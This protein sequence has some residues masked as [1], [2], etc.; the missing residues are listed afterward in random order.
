M[1]RKLAILLLAWLLPTGRTSEVPVIGN[2]DQSSNNNLNLLHGGPTTQYATDNKKFKIELLLPNLMVESDNQDSLVTFN[3]N[4]KNTRFSYNL[5]GIC[6]DCEGIG[7]SA[8]GGEEDFVTYESEVSGVSAIICVNGPHLSGIITDVGKGTNFEIRTNK[9]VPNTY[10]Y[11]GS[12]LEDADIHMTYDVSEEIEVEPSES[13]SIELPGHRKML[14]EEKEIMISK[15]V[16][17]NISPR[18]STSGTEN[19]RVL[20]DDDDGSEVTLLYYITKRQ[21][22]SWT[23]QSY[24]S[25]ILDE[26]KQNELETDVAVITAYANKALS[27]SDVYFTFVTVKVHVDETNDE[28]VHDINYDPRIRLHEFLRLGRYG[29]PNP[30]IESL[31]DEYHADLVVD[32][33]Y[34]EIAPNS[35][36]A[37]GVGWVPEV[38]PARNQGYSSTGGSFSM[39]A[40]V[41]THEIGHNMGLN[42]N[43][44]QEAGG[45]KE[46]YYGW[47]DCE[48]C[49]I[50]IM[51]YTNECYETCDGNVQKI[52]YFSNQNKKFNG[53][54][55]GDQDND[56]ASVLNLTKEGVAMQRYTAPLKLIAVEDPYVSQISWADAALVFDVVPKSDIILNNI[57]FVLSGAGSFSVYI[58]IGSSIGNE[59]NAEFW[60]SPHMKGTV[61]PR[62]PSNRFLN[63]GQFED[64]T[65]LMLLANQVYAIKISRNPGSNDIIGKFSASRN[66]AQGDVIVENDHISVT[67][68][69]IVTQWFT[70]DTSLYGSLQYLTSSD[71]SPTSTPT[72]KSTTFA[73]TSSAP[74]FKSTT[75]APTTSVPTFKSTTSA[76]TT[77][78]LT[79]NDTVFKF[80]KKKNCA[81]LLPSQ[82]KKDR[83]CDKADD[84]GRIVKNHCPESCNYDCTE[85]CSDDDAF[86]I[87]VKVDGEMMKYT[88]AK[89]PNSFVNC[90]TYDKK[91]KA[92]VGEY[93]R[94]SCGIC[95]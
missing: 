68:G 22:C 31:R 13:S 33:F 75:S 23:D 81:K 93:C 40:S 5:D 72:F 34:I 6:H 54:P 21:M 84:L 65:E 78:A 87:K 61:T 39:I 28:G 10:S 52:Q 50:T 12:L 60:K 70:Y 15:E 18:L 62:N 29:Q 38:F 11:E 92:L 2:F 74:T 36:G 58:S 17:A 79:C 1:T 94:A 27:N 88:C 49:F 89:I 35:F 46:V 91:K 8:S 19:R 83:F 66:K 26:A 80:N 69:V 42:H 43:R 20:N 77:S 16:S 30:D 71:P 90:F 73:P 41:I 51:S 3:C 63:G 86:K 59:R 76:P 9:L 44:Y 64:F 4:S 48:N 32:V 7:E 82:K 85:R 57:E 53:N 95:P 14:G 67:K 55:M 47:S 24:D 25:C 45:G 37:S 56:C